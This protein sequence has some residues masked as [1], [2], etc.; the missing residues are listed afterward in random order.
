MIRRLATLA[1]LCLALCAGCRE[2]GSLK[3]GVSL[4]TQREERWVRDR[5]A[6]EE[7]AKKRGIEL[8]VEVAD[9]DPS[10]QLEQSTQLIQSG[11]KVLILGPQ[12]TSAAAAIVDK[13]SAAG[14]KVID[15]DRL[16]RGTSAD[17]VF[18]SFDNVKIGEM[19][20]VFLTRAKPK[21]NYVVLAGSPSD[22][23]ARLYR[24]GAMRFITPLV[25]K[26]D[27][28]VVSDQWVKDWQPA[29]AERLMEQALQQ[30]PVDAVLAPNDGTA[31]GCIHALAAHGL[32]GKV[33]VT[34]QD[35]ELAAVR[36]LMDGTQ[37]MTV[38][39]DT[40]ELGRKAIE[41]AVDLA[42][43]R[44]VDTQNQTL[45]NGAR[46]VPSVL[47]PA[48]VVTKDNVDETVVRSGYLTHDQIVAR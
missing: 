45:F 40:R 21:G 35:A 15:Y 38:F 8:R 3:I 48:Y 22:T 23:N 5:A 46:N 33:P 44:A 4:P 12:D 20:G 39:K 24:D 28:R 36:R 29:E 42:E 9:N 27:V 10:R 31:A 34:G 17:F 19:Q 16:V 37:S 1:S 26:G 18:L 11:V 32:A 7:A 41:I 43:G 14:V 6:M 47:L 13:A 2:K 25:T 30:G